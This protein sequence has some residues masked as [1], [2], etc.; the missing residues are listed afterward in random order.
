MIGG[1]TVGYI[2]LKAVL[3]TVIN[4]E[5]IK[6]REITWLDERLSVIQMDVAAYKTQFSAF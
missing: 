5:F 2:Y 6:I 3:N 1:E 4:I